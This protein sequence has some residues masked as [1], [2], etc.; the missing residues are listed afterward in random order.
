MFKK[1][2]MTTV[3]ALA[4][5]VGATSIS[6]PDAEAGVRVNLSFGGGGY[7]GGPYYGGGYGGHGHHF[8]SYRVRIKYW[9]AGHGHMHR[10]WVWR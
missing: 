8:G 10:R 9:H 6:T 3:A 7:W 4:I 1:I 2:L 5:T